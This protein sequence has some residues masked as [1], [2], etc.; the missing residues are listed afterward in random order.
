MAERKAL[1]VIGD[2]TVP[3][4]HLE[5]AWKGINEYY[6]PSRFYAVHINTGEDFEELFSSHMEPGEV[7]GLLITDW[8]LLNS[9]DF[10]KMV[11]KY[12]SEELGTLVPV[13]RL[14]KDY[15]LQHWA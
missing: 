4:I 11:N 10:T 1:L 7:L 8:E 14:D 5:N 15:R 3:K 2:I 13:H 9:S 12:R 6:K